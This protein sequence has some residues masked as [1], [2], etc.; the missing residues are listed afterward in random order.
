MINTTG[1]SNRLLPGLNSGETQEPGNRYFSP[2]PSPYAN[3]DHSL[4]PRSSL[5]RLFTSSSTNN[6]LNSNT[7]SPTKTPKPTP[8]KRKSRSTGLEPKPE[9]IAPVPATAPAKRQRKKKTDTVAKPADQSSVIS[10]LPTLSNSSNST[11]LQPNQ[12]PNTLISTGPLMI[13]T[14]VINNRLL[15]GLNSGEAQDTGNRYFSPLP[16]PYTNFDHQLAPRSNLSRLFTSSLTNN[17]SNSADDPAK[18]FEELRENTW[19]HLSRCVLE[20]AQQFDIPSL[21]G[22]LYT[23]RS[24][25]EK[26]VNKVRDLTMKRDQLIAMNAR[27]DLPGPMLTQHLNN[28]SPNFASLV[29]GLTNSPKS[30]PSSSPSSAIAKQPL[31]S[32]GS[33]NH[34]PPGSLGPPG[35]LDRSSP[36]VSQTHS[37]INNITK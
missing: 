8:N 33:F 5:S 1:I 27:L 15:P 22:T 7:S 9:Q 10:S 18:A 36:L 32:V 20:Q 24:E 13:N 12:T 31:V 30:L 23:I 14:P 25:N 4:A 16:S 19:S 29:S 11:Q 37:G 2:L 6:N 28:T 34:V 26:L 21:I 35:F 17:L 3:F